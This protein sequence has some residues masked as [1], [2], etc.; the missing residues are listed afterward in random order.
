MLFKIILMLSFSW[1]SLA[2]FPNIMSTLSFYTS[3]HVGK[4]LDLASIFAALLF[5]DKIKGRISD[6]PNIIIHTL[7]MIVS[8]GRISKYLD[9]EELII[10]NFVKRIP[11]DDSFGSAVVISKCSFSWGLKASDKE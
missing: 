3:I 5:F 1:S 11:Q 7:D 2:F 4:K 6:L 9:S 10:A 8:M